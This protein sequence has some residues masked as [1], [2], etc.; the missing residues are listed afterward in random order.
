[1]ANKQSV[2]VPSHLFQ[3]G[4]FPDVCA[5][6]GETTS[7]KRSLTAARNSP[8]AIVGLVGGV[9]GLIVALAITR[10]TLDGAVPFASQPQVVERKR[11][12]GLAMI[13]GG[14]VVAALT[15]TDTGGL[16]ALGLM[17]V[18]VAITGPFIILNANSMGITAELSKD[19]E[20][21]TI[22]K[23][24]A[25]FAEA[26]R[27]ATA[28]AMSTY[29]GAPAPYSPYQVAPA[30]LGHSEWSAVPVPGVPAP[31]APAAPVAHADP[32]RS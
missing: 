21:V 20:T 29:S 23:V 24:H 11:L 7:E 27:V 6:T 19:K 22:K 30:G 3:V 4:A 18:L 10:K 32:F 16:A 17:G 8:W 5:R 13:V 26:A 1:M 28:E 9:I 14:L 31:V 15:I 12:I 2:S 25:G